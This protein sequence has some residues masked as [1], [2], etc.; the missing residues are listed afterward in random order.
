MSIR[1]ARS[2]WGSL[3]RNTAA[4]VSTVKGHTSGLA[5]TAAL[6]SLAC[7]NIDDASPAP[8]FFS[9]AGAPTS[10]G[11]GAVTGAGGWSAGGAPGAANSTGGWSSTGT[12]GAPPGPNSP[13]SGSGGAPGA[14][15]S[16][17]GGAPAT[18]DA[19]CSTQQPQA[20]TSCAAPEG[21]SCVYGN[22]A[23]YCLTGA[24]ACALSVGGSSG[25]GGWN[26][27]A[28]A[29]GG[30]NSGRS[31]GGAGGWSSGS[32]GAG[33]SAGRGS[34]GGSTNG[35]CPSQQPSD[36][37]SCSSDG[38]RCSFGN[39]ECGCYGGAWRC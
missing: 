3:S 25:T 38:T 22:I 18:P 33:G 39:S 15:S 10:F 35:S 9:G 28:P 17:T 24:W 7:G 14:P 20:G 16:D 5:I 8:E 2:V 26:S 32:S 12:S 21:T 4:F 36:G 11:S 6:F 27:G 19:N 23:C 30:W 13:N 1:N 31:S 29:T 37:D 34:T